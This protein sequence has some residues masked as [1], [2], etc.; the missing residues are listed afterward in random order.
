MWG[1]LPEPGI[2]SP[3]LTGSVKAEYATSCSAYAF[4]AG[5]CDAPGSQSAMA[6]PMAP[7]ES[8]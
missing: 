8:S 6:F 7:A 4:F 3:E 1:M 2:I 5:F